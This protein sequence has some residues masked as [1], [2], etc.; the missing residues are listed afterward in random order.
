MLAHELLHRE[1]AGP[2]ALARACTTAHL[3]DVPGAVVQGGVDV[4]VGDDAAVADDHKGKASLSM[5]VRSPV[6]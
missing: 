6:S 1:D 2:A 4:T 5:V 3:G